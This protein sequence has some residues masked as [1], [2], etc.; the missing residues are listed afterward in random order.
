KLHFNKKDT[1]SILKTKINANFKSASI[2][3]Y[4][5]KLNINNLLYNNNGT[6]IYLGDI[7]L[8][9]RDKTNYLELQSDFIDAVYYGPNDLS[10]FINQLKYTAQKYI[11]DLFPLQSETSSV[12]HLESE[13]CLRAQIKEVKGITQIFAPGLYIENGSELDLVIDTASR[14]DLRLVSDKIVYEKNRISKVKLLCNNISDTLDLS[15]FGDLSV[16]GLT[17]YNFQVK[18]LVSN[19]IIATD[20]SFLDSKNNSRANISTTSH[21]SKE[22]ESGKLS[23]IINLN[24]SF[25]TFFGQK[26]EL[27]SA[28]VK[29]NDNSL[30]IQ[31]FNFHQNGQQIKISGIVSK[32]D[33][34]SLF[35]TVD[36]YML[37][38]LNPYIESNG[39]SLYGVVSG[40]FEIVGLYG[41]PVIIG[42]IET[43]D[44]VING[45]T[46]GNAVIGSMWNDNKQRLD[47]TAR[48]YDSKKVN[49]SINGYYVPSTDEITANCKIIDLR[50]NS[51][52]PF[53]QKI[54][55][56]ISGSAQGNIDLSGTLKNPRLSGLLT[57][58]DVGLTVNY[59]KTHYV[60]NSDINISN[61]R[62][63]ISNGQIKDV[64]GNTGI[65]NMDLTHNYFTNIEFDAKANITNFMSL[66]TKEKDNPLFYG[67]AYASGVVGLSG[68]ADH[69]NLSVTAA[70]G[71]NSIL[72]IPLSSTSQ[73]KEF[74]F[75]TFV[76][77]LPDSGNAAPPVSANTNTQT[78]I[79]IGFDLTVTPESEIQ[80]LIDPKVG[81]ILK[82][83]GNGNLKINVNPSIDHFSILGD[84]VIESGDYNFT[85]PNF[86]ILSRKFLIDKGS[87]V[88]FNG[89]ATD[90]TLNVSASYKERVSLSALFPEDSLRNYPV[91]CQILITGRMTNPKLK[92]NIEIQDVDPE[93]KAQFLSLVNTEEKMTKQFL[94]ILVLRTFLPEQSLANQDLGSS[95]LLS[96]ASDLLSSQISSLISLFK[97]PVPLDVNVGYNANA[98][99]S[100]G[101]EFEVDFSTQ[102]F[103]RVIINGSASNA[104]HS[105]RGFVGDFE[106][107][108][109]LG[110]YGH[111]RFKVFSKSRDYFSDDMDNNRNGIGISYQ[112]QFNRFIDILR[113][114]K[115][116][117]STESTK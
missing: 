44:L 30:N 107:E 99:N 104:T 98:R 92:F 79:D 50:L 4:S 8:S 66:N 41:T 77:S 11:P 14:L 22:A 13:Y 12:N 7:V 72:Y 38:G 17:L 48:I 53:L 33:T 5:G 76:N 71:A 109:L 25:M 111:T 64:A 102:L 28:N 56:D 49:T 68:T 70:T 87:S 20:I 10:G 27:E 105:N 113:R 108:V 110:K 114:K 60:V 31:G 62:M 97:L 94:S 58:K 80:I 100:S 55:S 117:N 81:D 21:F 29:L 43:N 115:K 16:S 59:I 19:N 42:G 15:L 61:S 67:A 39:Y 57:L 26:W 35:V 54:L 91:L 9:N 96:N 18:N 82:T 40:G 88:H 46:L 83:K 116:N 90:A 32:S 52:E 78:N 3:D 37:S 95:A 65:L 36:N 112:S 47:I 75:L 74:E 1:V 34:D 103:N 69:L 93:K 6:E 86:S 101:S 24:K 2:L 51:I 23:S 106:A 45:D 63:N 89:D 85:L 84:Y 73:A